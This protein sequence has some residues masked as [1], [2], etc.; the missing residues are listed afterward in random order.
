[1][2]RDRERSAIDQVSTGAGVTGDPTELFDIT[3]PF[4]SSFAP[5]GRFFT[6]MA[7]SRTGITYD[8]RPAT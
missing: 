1:M 8:A 6:G 5:Q 3:R 7:A 2:S 4:Y